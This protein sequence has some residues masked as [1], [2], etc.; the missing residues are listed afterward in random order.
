DLRSALEQVVS[1][2]S[3]APNTLDAFADLISR[4]A[5]H[6]LN[7]TGVR[8]LQDIPT[9]VPE[10]PVPQAVAAE[11]VP[12][13]REALS[14]VLRHAQATE[15]WVRLRWDDATLTLEIEDN[16]RGFAE[17]E[18]RPGHGLANLRTRAQALGCR[19]EIDSAPGGGCRVR[20][21]ATV[22]RPPA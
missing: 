1:G 16:G 14:N 6:L 2:L 3:D 20:F 19:C 11:L 10:V 17:R 18:I 15:V 13:V 9:S 8:C 7:G 4:Q 12:C 21:S 22:P 5:D